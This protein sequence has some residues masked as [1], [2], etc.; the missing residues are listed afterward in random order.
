MPTPR[1]LTSQVYIKVAGADAQP[2]VTRRLIEV[3]IDQHAYLPALCTLRLHDPGLELVD[4]GPF[5]LTKELEVEA[6]DQS[7]QRVKLF[8]GEITALEPDFGE[9]MVAELVVRAYDKSHRLYRETKSA[10]FLNKKDSDLASDI[11]GAAGLQTQIDATTTVYEHIYQHNQTDLEFLMQ[12]AWRI[13]YECFV[14]DGKLYFRKPPTT[15][16]AV[17][18]RW[19]EQLISFRPRMTLAEQVDEAMVKGWDV[20]KK[21][22][23]VGRASSGNLYPKIQES[24]NG[25]AW[26]GAF[27]A[28]KLIVVDQPVV[29]QAEA[30]ILAAA[31]L[32]ERSGAFVQADGVATRRP[33][34]KAGQMIKLEALG[35]R[36]SGEYLVTNAT[37]VYNANGWRTTF[38]VQG[39][40]TGLVAEQIALQ[41]PLD[42]WPGVVAA[43]VTNTEDPNQWGRVK[44]K[45][46]W[47]SEDAESDWA[48]VVGAGAGPEA[49][50]F[51]LP[52]VDD[53]VLVAF[54]HGD[55]ARPYV[56]GGVWNGQHKIP[57]EVSA[58]PSNEKPLVRT[59]HSRTG[60]KI[61]VTETSSEKKM[62]IITAGGHSILLDD[63]NKKVEIKTT[64]GHQVTVD[65][66]G[67]KLEL[68]SS[69][70][71]KVTMDDM[72]NK[73]AVQGGMQ[74]EIKS[75]GN[76]TIEAG[77]MMDIKASGPVNIKG[78]IV[79]LN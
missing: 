71:Q 26:A 6:A 19:G 32:D 5:D 3:V 77:G 28:G 51:I 75:S 21:Q 54:E 47:L 56:L 73:L 61:I 68:A 43:L 50:L 16:A 69:G 25:A 23:I 18:I 22:A 8:K 9:N 76:M 45:F 17:T 20:E 53:E 79:N 4:N 41:S 63:T 46:P 55:F 70:G 7:G 14:E 24:K 42:R 57:P 36:F 78:A 31:R 2:T 72:G 74:V 66:Q 35:D 33:E 64:G 15:S 48:R 37:H 27:G 52:E 10:A 30:D 34:I 44:V 1:Q 49:G 12:R 58:A 59:W 40:R 39:S 60:H 29:S 38:T 11:A 13:G 65:D 67:K 62:E